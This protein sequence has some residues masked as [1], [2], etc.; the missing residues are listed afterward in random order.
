M[1][2]VVVVVVAAVSD[3]AGA[4]TL[5]ADAALPAI[6]PCDKT[7]TNLAGSSAAVPRGALGDGG[8]LDAHRHVHAQLHL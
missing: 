8:A 5:S 4:R 3:A 6:A 7:S 1:V 2:A